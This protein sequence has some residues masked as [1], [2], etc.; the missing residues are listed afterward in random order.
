M[1]YIEFSVHCSVLYWIEWIRLMFTL[2]SYLAFSLFVSGSGSGSGFSHSISSKLC[3]SK[4]FSGLH[5]HAHC[6]AYPAKKMK[7]T[8]SHSFDI[9]RRLKIA[10]ASPSRGKKWE[11]RKHTTK[12]KQQNPNKR[13][14]NNEPNNIIRISIRFQINYAHNNK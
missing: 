1:C 9:F 8:V 7:I 5:M 3:Q 10:L 13:H 12:L 2:N 11:S 4:V 6:I 14:T